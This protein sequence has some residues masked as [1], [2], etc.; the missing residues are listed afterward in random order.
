[1]EN[2]KQNSDGKSYNV[3]TEEI[4]EKLKAICGEKFVASDDES[5][6]T[7]GSDETED[8]FFKP[9]VVVKP[10]DAKQI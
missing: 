3:V 10:A 8:L 9:E 2:L 6:T 1:M 4:L 7:Y 5:C